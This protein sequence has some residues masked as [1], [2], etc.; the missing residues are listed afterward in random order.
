MKRRSYNTGFQIAGIVVVFGS[1]AIILSGIIGIWTYTS[2]SASIANIDYSC[3][4]QYMGSGDICHASGKDYTVTEWMNYKKQE[5]Q[6]RQNNAFW[7]ALKNSGICLGVV[8]LF[9]IVLSL[10]AI[11]RYYR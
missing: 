3:E 4:G 11:P 1:I 6:S 8:A 7:N 5:A 9:I 10:R 2:D